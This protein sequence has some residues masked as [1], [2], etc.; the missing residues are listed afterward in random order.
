[1]QRAQRA[2]SKRT[3]FAVAKDILSK[4]CDSVILSHDT[5]ETIHKTIRKKRLSIGTQSTWLGYP[6]AGVRALSSHTELI[7]S[8]QQPRKVTSFH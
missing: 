2:V 6:D 1:M 4:L 8:S 5:F 3:L 7:K